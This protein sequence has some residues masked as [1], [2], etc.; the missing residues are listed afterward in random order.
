MYH[1]EESAATNMEVEDD[2]PWMEDEHD[3]VTGPGQSD[4]R[5]AQQEWDKLALRYSDVSDEA[6]PVSVM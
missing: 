5:V 1:G 3:H 4:H 2:S 6:R